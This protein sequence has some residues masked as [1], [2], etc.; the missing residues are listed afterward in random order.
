MKFLCWLGIHKWII[1]TTKY[2]GHPDRRSC[3]RCF[4]KQ[5]ARDFHAIQ[6]GKKD[7]YWQDIE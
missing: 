3:L 1:I 5:Q 7:Y 6:L 4:K 2:G